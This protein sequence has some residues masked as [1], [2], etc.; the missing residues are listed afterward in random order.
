MMIDKFEQFWNLYSKEWFDN[1]TLK[2]NGSIHAVSEYCTIKPD[3]VHELYD[4]YC[5]IKRILKMR[6]YAGRNPLLNR[7]RR[8]AALAYAIN[9]CAPLEYRNKDKLH[10]Y[11]F[12]VQRLAFY[13]ALSS[14]I[15]EYPQEEVEKIQQP[16]FA[17]PKRDAYEE[18]LN[19]DDF[20]TSVY[21]DLYL[22]KEYKNFNV[23]TLSN[24]LW[25]IVANS[26]LGTVSPLSPS[27]EK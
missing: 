26:P 9:E 13:V 5:E 1:A 12:L 8:A 24:V 21:K 16:L 6:Y 7:Y 10:E 20:L 2:E 11:K 19:G 25:L 23:L 27:N 4:T 17:F 22:A 14:I 18:E 3:C 15:I